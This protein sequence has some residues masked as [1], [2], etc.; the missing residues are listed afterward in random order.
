MVI[1]IMYVFFSNFVNSKC[2]I[3]IFYI[4]SLDMARTKAKFEVFL[5]L[6]ILVIRVI[7]VI[8]VIFNFR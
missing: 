5:I 6:V 1:M 4:S 8:M 7:M 2:V 3:G